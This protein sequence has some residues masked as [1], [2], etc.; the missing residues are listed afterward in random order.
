MQEAVDSPWWY[1]STLALGIAG[2]VL[3]WAAFPPLAWGPLA[4]V[5]PI[6]WLVLIRR[7]VLAGRRPYFKLYLAGLVFWLLTI[8]WLRL[9][10]PAT[11]LG[12]L[13]LSAYLACYLPLFVG[14]SR[15][16]VHRGGM[17]LW[18]APPA[19]WTGLELA[20]AHLIT[21]FL[22][23]ALG[24]TQVRFPQL[25]QISD[26]VG[27]YG[28]SFL[29]ML[30]AACLT[31]F[32]PGGGSPTR[33][34]VPATVAVIA[35]AATLLYG[36]F[37]LREFDA[38][39]ANDPTTA[40]PRVAIIQGNSL[41]T[42]KQERNKT[43][44]IMAEYVGLSEMAV[45]EASQLSD[46]RPVDLVIWPETMFRT[47]LV[48]ADEGATLPADAT[49]TLDEW[50]SYAPNELK[51]LTAHLGTAVLVGIDR[52]HVVAAPPE[53]DTGFP[54]LRAYN[55]SVLVDAEGAI[56][57]TYDKVHRVMFGEYVPLANW[58]P[59]F[60]RIVAIVGGIEA[61][62]DP[63][64]IELGGV[65]YAP[66]I[67]YETVLPHVI[68]RQYAELTARKMLPDVLVNLTNDAWFWG[69]SELDMHLACDVFRAVECRTPL[70]V[71]A[72]GGIS[73]SID[74]CG[75]IVRQGPRMAT[76]VIIADVTLDPRQSVYAATG[77]WFAGFCLL[78]C[79]GSAIVGWRR[80][81]S[82]A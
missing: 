76:D 74:S 64:A 26:L 36:Q 14:L 40:G 31:A 79:V 39:Q 38:L 56:R 73:A 33:R 18:L 37:R 46:G 71:A 44:E 29:V 4:W 78:C 21:G 42:W 1:R 22:M 30:V 51:A 50:K 82:D 2:S 6:P 32:V 59:F 12:W 17:P 53:D 5:A 15:A 69:S 49:A 35:L 48:T 20:R 41:A 58:V 10:H 11:P 57:G 61:G 28:A 34:W 67:C 80:G 81:P 55:S 43:H 24:H 7:P 16:A 23:A 25:I 62:V 60:D 47:S 13:A 9:P 27:S 54:P 77:D 63:V 19:V 68:R 3:L 45:R 52:R 65:H 70:V 72:N 75:R 66:N 8:H